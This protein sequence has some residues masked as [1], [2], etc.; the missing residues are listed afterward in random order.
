MDVTLSSLPAIEQP[1]MQKVLQNSGFITQIA[2]TIEGP[3]HLVEPETFA[4]NLNDFEDILQKHQVKGHVFYAKKANK[5]A[6]WLKVAAL[7]NGFADV[8]S[9]PEFA[10]ALACG[11]KGNHIGVTGAAKSNDLL[12]LANQHG[13]LVAIDA[14]DELERLLQSQKSRNPCG[15]YCV[16]CHR[17]FLTAASG[18]IPL[19]YK[20]RC[21]NVLTIAISSPWKVF[22]SISMAMRL[23]RGQHSLFT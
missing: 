22:L 6:I 10:H 21:K 15:Y 1:W 20:W 14:L 5:A 2:D 13:A 3:F 11:I 23:A 7:F 18:L 9:L 12:R 8:A 19:I 16:F 4:H 17:N